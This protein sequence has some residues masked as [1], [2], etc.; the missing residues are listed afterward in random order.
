MKV[1][2]AQA[3]KMFR[4]DTIYGIKDSTGAD[5]IIGSIQNSYDGN[6]FFPGVIK[7]ATA[8]WF[9]FATSQMFFNGNKRT[10]LM[11]GLYFLAVNGFSWPNING[12]EL[13]SITVA[14]A[15]KDISQSELE[16]YIRGKTGLQYFSTPK[17]ALDNST[18]TLKFHFTIDNPN[19]NP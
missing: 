8:Y 17:Q 12:N 5:R 10:A 14:V 19:I 18:A 15:N 7:K 6:D 13:Y 3:E 16:S 1:I 9:K 4:E 2:N 11:S